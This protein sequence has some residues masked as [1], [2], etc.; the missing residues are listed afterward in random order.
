MSSVYLDNLKMLL[1]KCKFV[2]LTHSETKQTKMLEFGA[3]KVIAGHC[4][5]PK[6]LKG[7]G[8]GIFKGKVRKGRG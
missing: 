1:N 4:K 5:S 3:E 2:C 7:F 8:E 6:L